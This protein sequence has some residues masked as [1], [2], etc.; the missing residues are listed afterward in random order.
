MSGV[1]PKPSGRYPVA[2]KTQAAG[3]GGGLGAAIAVALIQMIQAYGTH[4]P[5][6]AG[7]QVLIT[8]AVSGALAW[9]SAYLAPHQD[10]VPGAQV[11]PPPPGGG[12]G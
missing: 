5:L 10:R 3:G 7:A 4:K 8:M 6:A 2:A 9:L 12:G 1:P 11:Q